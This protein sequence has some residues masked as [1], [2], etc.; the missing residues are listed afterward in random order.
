M[1]GYGCESRHIHQCER[2]EIGGR[3]GFKIRSRKGCRFE[4][5]RSYQIEV[6]YVVA[7]RKT[8]DSNT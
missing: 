5:D 6:S 7:T 1:G 4:S 8:E 2:G 3:A